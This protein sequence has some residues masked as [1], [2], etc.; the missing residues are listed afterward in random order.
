MKKEESKKMR[1]LDNLEKRVIYPDIDFYG[2]YKHDGKDIYLCN[3]IEKGKNDEIKVEC[4]IIDNI[5]ITNLER[6]YVSKYGK[7]VKEKTTQKVELREGELLVYIPGLGFTIPEYKMV[8]IPEAIDLYKLI[9]NEKEPNK[10][11]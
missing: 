7:K 5:L 6:E 10:G 2:A 8:T 9:I 1:Q 11:E 3:D 4:Y